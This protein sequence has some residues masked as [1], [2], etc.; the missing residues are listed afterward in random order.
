VRSPWRRRSRWSPAKTS[1]RYG[2]ICSGRL[3]QSSRPVRTEVPLPASG[4]GFDGNPVRSRLRA[5][6]GP[7]GLRICGAPLII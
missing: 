7:R 2:S 5:L 1:L 3:L 4:S 6:E